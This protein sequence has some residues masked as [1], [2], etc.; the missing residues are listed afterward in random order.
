MCQF[1]HACF[2]RKICPQ[3][4]KV[5]AASAT[6]NIKDFH[7]LTVMMGLEGAV[8]VADE[9]EVE[10]A[11][12]EAQ[13]QDEQVALKHFTLKLDRD[14]ARWDKFVQ[15]KSDHEATQRQEKLEFV[16]EQ[17]EKLMKVC[18]GHLGE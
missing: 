9:F 12:D 11:E 2:C 16:L 17:E 15:A 13:C 6:L 3:V 7:F 5:K 18:P 8:T 1:V 14:V 10:V 4:D